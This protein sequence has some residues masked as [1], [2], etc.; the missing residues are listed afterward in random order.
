MKETV[1]TRIVADKH[2]WI[3]EQK[4]ARP[5]EDFVLDVIPS[6]RDFYAAL[7]KSEPVFI[8]ECKKASPSKGLIRADF[9]PVA[10]ARTYAPYASVISVLTDEKYFQGSFSFLPQVRAQ[11]TQPVLCKDFI[12]DPYQIYL[13]RL[14]QA[15]AVLLMLSVLSDEQ[16][17]ALHAIA[18]TLSM[19]VLTEVS[20]SEEAKRAVALKARVVGIN[21]RNLRDL[22]IDLGRTAELAALLSPETII[23]S[24]SGIHQHQQ[25]V[26]LSRTAQGFLIGSALMAENDLNSAIR[27]LIYGENKVCGLTRPDD[28]LAA[29]QAGAYYGGLIFVGKSPRYVDIATA[30]AVQAAAPLHYVGVFRNAKIETICLTVERLH[31]AAVQLHGDESADYI[32]QLR[33]QLP[34]Q[35]QIWKAIAVNPQLD[36]LPVVALP[37]IDRYLL[38]TQLNGQSGGTGQPF[39]WQLL[40]NLPQMASESAPIGLN[41]TLLA[42]GLSPDNAVAAQRFATAGLDFNSGLESAPGIKSKEKMDITFLRLRQ[43]GVS[44]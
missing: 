34:A 30:K 26:E 19:G 20:N 25:V 38:D 24:E 21:N 12:V 42:G 15:D 6:D 27:R 14:H 29:Y 4:A 35:C 11:V 8:L 40:N 10:I 2:L 44:A 7:H 36:H 22:S 32:T 1:L 31:L 18:E 43:Q 17:L 39:N 3:A 9:D 41:N 16:Y 5:L 23:I 13:A 37:H 28:A 33:A